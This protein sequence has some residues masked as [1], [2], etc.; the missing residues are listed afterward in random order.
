MKRSH[1]FLAI[2]LACAG[3]QA[4]ETI[5]AAAPAAK[6]SS[7]AT[8][9]PVATISLPTEQARHELDQMRE[10]MRDLGRRVAELS[11]QLG[12]DSPRN[13][14]WRYLSDPDRAMIGIVMAPDSRGVRIAGIT[15]GG[16][17]AKAG[18]KN[19]DVL[20]IVNGK[21]LTADA[22]AQG[23][24]VAEA[25][26]ALHDLKI[27]QDVLLTVLRDGKK[28][29]VVV[30]AERREPRS[31]VYALNGDDAHRVEIAHNA[32]V[33]RIMRA[34]R[35]GSNEAHDFARTFHVRMPWWGL[36]LVS[37]DKDLSAYF[38]TERG[39][40]VLNADTETFPGLRSGDVMQSIGGEIVAG[41]EDAMRLLRDA[42]EGGEIEVQVVR[43]K[44]PV[45]LTMKTPEFKAI[46]PLP[47]LP[48][49]PPLPP[50]APGMAPPAPPSAPMPPPTP[51]L[52]HDA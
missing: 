7:I 48:P 6:A 21:A 37:L 10:Q 33:E 28:S 14:A 27:G 2:A 25:T 13:Y 36:N 4:A 5:P 35:R 47:P 18:I 39:A 40:L 44:K 17:A 29:N 42:P 3:A 24:A 41:P 49:E 22:D 52:P 34:T 26:A 19:N 43:Q 15:P 31:F 50:H 23:K 45:T 11:A 9:T 30:K 12:D 51:T 32:D 8:A 1:L 16:P 46:F 38:G 20:M